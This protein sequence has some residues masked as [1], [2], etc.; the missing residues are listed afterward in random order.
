MTKKSKWIDI[1]IFNLVVVA[2]LG[3]VL[4]S[5]I[6]FA[7]PLI[8]YNHLLEGHSH[9]TFGGWVTLVIM[10]LMVY[11]L[12]PAAFHKKII[13]QWILAGIA[14]SAWGTLITFFLEGYS[15]ISI[16]FSL[17]FILLTYIFSII[18]IRDIIKAKSGR[19]VLLLA[20]SSMACLILSSAGTFIITYIYF[21]KS[22]EAFLYRDALFTYL[23]FQYNG[24]FS[25][26][27][28][29]LLF[30]H[31]SKNITEK[32]QKNMYRFSVVLCL[33][34][35]PSL[36][37]SY[38]WQDP[39]LVFRVIAIAGSLLLLLSCI[40]FILF[41]GSSLSSY[42]QEKPVIRFLIFLSMSA[43]LLKLFLQCFTI[44][45]VIGNAIFGNRPIIM[46][47]LHLVFLGFVTLFILAFFA[48]TNLL[49]TTKAST[50]I[51]LITLAVA[52]IFNEALL[53]AQGLTTMF[54]PGSV[55][56]PWL[57]L[58]AGAGLFAGTILIVIARIQTKKTASKFN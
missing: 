54:I 55:L 4:R 8:N 29:A 1:A 11:E 51:A 24:F 12:L 34:I 10:A 56:F 28:F 43:F 32:T 23:H 22:F 7:L 49:D 35:I 14:L 36:F 50:R 19:P 37:L 41:S 31:L 57:L 27:I 20:I 46:G 48:K 52:V 44:F 2:L 26:A 16:I 17:V 30:N 39:K 13:Y 25:L 47:F 45:P 9:F 53:I 42:R 18:F 58:F 3:V 21:T 6:L 38:L 33:S 40:L 5:K 15:T